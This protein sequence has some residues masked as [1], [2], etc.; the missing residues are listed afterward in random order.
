M[1]KK[2]KQNSELKRQEK[3]KNREEQRK[4]MI[5]D[6]KKKSKQKEESKEVLIEWYGQII[7][8]NHKKEPI[9][10]ESINKQ[11]IN[12]DLINK[13]II[14][15]EPISN[16]PIN[17][18]PINN[19]PINNEPINKEIIQKELKTRKS[20]SYDIIRKNSSENSDVS[21][22]ENE[23]KEE[24]EDFYGN[25]QEKFE[26]LKKKNLIKSD[27][28]NKNE[29][30]EKNINSEENRIKP[31]E[32]TEKKHEKWHKSNEELTS[33][34]KEDDYIEQMINELQ[35]LVDFLKT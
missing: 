18:E 16:E 2:D 14:N 11:P 28:N 8:V 5:E 27:E 24:N 23:K 21:S 33:Y 7:P 1:K 10:K 31:A 32:E 35:D 12:K 25:H 29:I 4:K 17:D 6:M 13:E 34:G 26:I 15:N 20:I 19:E 22:H 30:F 3:E 9:K